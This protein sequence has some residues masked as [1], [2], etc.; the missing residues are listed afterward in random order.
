MLEA[1]VRVSIW[2]GTQLDVPVFTLVRFQ[3][4]TILMFLRVGSSLLCASHT[5][6]STCAWEICFWDWSRFPLDFFQGLACH[7][8]FLDM[9]GQRADGRRTA[10]GRRILEVATPPRQSQKPEE[11][12]GWPPWSG[13]CGGRRRLPCHQDRAKSKEVAMPPRQGQT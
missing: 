13:G 8:H 6:G 12:K 9:V 2:L 7:S 11:N 5:P 1:P 4:S 3:A 10:G